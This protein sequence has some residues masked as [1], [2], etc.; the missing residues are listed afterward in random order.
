MEGGRKEAERE[1]DEGTEGKGT[2]ETET[3]GKR[4]AGEREREI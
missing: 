4:E 1:R 2:R 3:D